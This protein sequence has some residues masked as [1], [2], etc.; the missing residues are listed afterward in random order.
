[1]RHLKQPGDLVEAIPVPV[2]E[3]E[4]GSVPRRQ[5]INEFGE[6]E[7]RG[8]AVLRARKGG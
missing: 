8:S 6:R 5:A 7:V 4:N 3:D 2:V 1:M